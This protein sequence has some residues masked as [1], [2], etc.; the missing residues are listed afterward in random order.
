MRCL[1]HGGRKH[2]AND[3]ETPVFHVAGPCPLCRKKVMQNPADH[4]LFAE[5][6]HDATIFSDRKVKRMAF[7]ITRAKQNDRSWLLNA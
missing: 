3:I 5:P 1:G 2:P 6:F 7:G 4:H